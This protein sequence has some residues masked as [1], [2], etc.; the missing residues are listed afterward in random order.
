MTPTTE[1]TLATQ[2]TAPKPLPVVAI[3]AR[4]IDEL[5]SQGRLVFP[6]DYSVQ[7]ALAS[8]RLML[9]TTEDSNRKRVLDQNGRGTGVV[10]DASICAAVLSMCVQGLNPDKKQCYF[11]VHGDQLCMRRSYFGEQS[12][13]IRAKPGCKPWADS[14]RK[15]E[16]VTTKKVMTSEGFIEIIESHEGITAPRN[17]EIV[18]GYAGITDSSGNFF[19][20]AMFDMPRIHK[21]WMQSPLYN[22][23]FQEKFPEEA[24]K[25]TMLRYVCKGIYNTSSDAL[26]LESIRSQEFEGVV[27]ELEERE[28]ANAHV[29]TL[30]VGEAPAL[31]AVTVDPKDDPSDGRNRASPSTATES[32]LGAHKESAPTQTTSTAKTPPKSRTE[33]PEPEDAP[34]VFEDGGAPY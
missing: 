31:E 7:N 6:A 32:A 10:T 30:T 34:E 19:A 23:G 13:A 17:P 28:E 29:G 25:R 16:V 21:S 22:K 24:V 15:G 14:I 8:A 12:L 18:G 1:T 2:K 5:T 9:L 27:A 33:S 20:F 3:V 4:Q 26:L 11:I